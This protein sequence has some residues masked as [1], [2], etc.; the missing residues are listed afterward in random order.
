MRLKG[1]RAHSL[2]RCVK[3]FNA[4]ITF[5]KE[6]D[7][8]IIFGSNDYKDLRRSNLNFNKNDFQMIVIKGLKT[9]SLKANKFWMRFI[10]LLFLVK[11][12]VAQDC[13]FGCRSD[14]SQLNLYNTTFNCFRI[15]DCGESN[16]TNSIVRG[17]YY[18]L[19]GSLDLNNAS[20]LTYDLRV[21]DS[22][23]CHSH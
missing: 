17:Q 12:V 21:K 10:I 5:K 11:L 19:S 15:I 14:E 18:K 20:I 3:T 22:D 13:Y 1:M 2:L 8:S 7:N 9:L 23:N 16:I 6:R 4:D